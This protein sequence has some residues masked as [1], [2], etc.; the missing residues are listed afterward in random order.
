MFFLYF[1]LSKE[2]LKLQFG[3]LSQRY[4]SYSTER[5]KQKMM[6]FLPFLSRNFAGV[7]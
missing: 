5:K 1:F 6:I 3:N 2:Q 7:F 4:F